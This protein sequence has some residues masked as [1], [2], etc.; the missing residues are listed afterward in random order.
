MAQKKTKKKSAKRVT[1]A[2][3]GKAK[4]LGKVGSKWDLGG[5]HKEPKKP[6]KPKKK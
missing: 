5:E 4:P 6:R 3:S 1:K 2:A